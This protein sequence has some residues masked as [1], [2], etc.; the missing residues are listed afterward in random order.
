MNKY[1]NY[2]FYFIKYIIYN[3]IKLKK[4]SFYYYQPYYYID[5]NLVILLWNSE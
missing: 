2:K 5:N 4:K 3:I 1:N